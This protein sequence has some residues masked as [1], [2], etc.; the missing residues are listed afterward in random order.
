MTQ[1]KQQRCFFSNSPYDVPLHRSGMYPW[2][3]YGAPCVRPLFVLRS[4]SHRPSV[5]LF[6]QT[7][8][9]HRNDV[10]LT[11]MRRHY[12]ASTSIRCRSDATCL[13]GRLYGCWHAWKGIRETYNKEAAD[14][15]SDT[16]HRTWR[17]TSTKSKTLHRTWR[18]TSTKCNGVLDWSIPKPPQ[19][20]PEGEQ[21]VS[22]NDL[23]Y[24][25]FCYWCVRELLMKSQWTGEIV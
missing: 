21:L 13:L 3:Q 23:S 20:G 16:L 10:L 19:R 24:C 14:K 9:I 1:A 15:M 5:L 2:L 12:V 8:T 17:R 6:S 25:R 18:R 4:S 11:W 22:F 7:G